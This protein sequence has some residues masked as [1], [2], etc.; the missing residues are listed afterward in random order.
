M[1]QIMSNLANASPEMLQ[2]LSNTPAIPP[3]VGVQPNFI[4]PE[5]RKLTQVVTTS[6]ILGFMVIFFINR[7]Y[8]KLF[9]MKRLTWDDATIVLAWFSCVAYYIG[10]T[11]GVERGRIGVHQWNIS[12]LQAA[13]MDLL[14]PA[15][16]I[17][18]LTPLTFLFLK[19]TFFILYL[20]LFE[21][22]NRLRIATWIGLGVTSL[23]Y[24]I[25]TI[26][27]FVYSTPKRGESWLA[28]QTTPNM[29]RQLQMS[30]PQSSIGLV[31]DLYILLIPIIG[32][33]GLRMS[34]KR[35]VGVM[36][37]FLSGLMA[38]IC[39]ACSIY[40]RVVL[41]HTADTTWHLIPVNIATLSEMFV[42]M[43]C[44]CMPSAAYA[45]R[46]ENSTYQKLVR[47]L[48]SHFDS[49]KS[50]WNRSKYADSSRGS[51]QEEKAETTHPEPDVLKSTDRK[52]A[53]YFS[54]N[55]TSFNGVETQTNEKENGMLTNDSRIASSSSELSRNASREKTSAANMV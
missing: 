49:L 10:C 55:D 41:D 53:Q 23:T 5:S 34:T 2:Y 9:L 42:G 16:L 46:R 50:S 31:I 11:W 52:Y 13:S 17:S 29:H 30:V 54:L 18:V 47:S 33:Y 3:P 37:I 28:H 20:Q 14:I 48:Y 27:V 35:K 38:C 43:I 22:Q 39:S 1:S 7:I 32:V 25:L 40:Y 15:Y 51:S 21:L 36:L 24:T 6:V 12:I 44:A 45:A 26:L 8:T 19:S 4:D